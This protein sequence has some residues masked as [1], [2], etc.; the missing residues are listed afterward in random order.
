MQEAAPGF[1]PGSRGFADLCLTTWLCR[2]L[3]DVPLPEACIIITRPGY[4]CK[5]FLRE[6]DGLHRCKV[7]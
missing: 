6:C 4:E 7:T 3:L 2:R 1:E 5:G